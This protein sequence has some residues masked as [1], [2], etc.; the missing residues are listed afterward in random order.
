MSDHIILRNV[1]ALRSLRGVGPAFFK[2]HL[3]IIKEAIS[4][5]DAY[6]SLA[7]LIKAKPSRDD[8]NGA[9][10]DAARTVER[11]HQLGIRGLSIT[12]PDY[13][14]KALEIAKP[15]PVL[16]VRGDTSLLK[17][18]TVGIIGTRQPTRTGMII[19]SRIG[20]YFANNHISICNGLADGVDASSIM[21]GDTCHAGSVGVM[22]GGLDLLEQRLSSKT[23][24]ER[25]AR[26]LASG[27]LLVSEA[28]PGTKEDTYSIISSCRVQA[29]LSD[30]M[31]LV[32]SSMTGGSR[33]A[34]AAFCGLPRVLAFIDPPEQERKDEAFSANVAMSQDQ[35][36]GLIA[37][38]DVKHV[39][40]TELVSLKSR[41]DYSIVLDRLCSG[42]RE[43]QS[44]RERGL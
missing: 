33:F 18:K 25:A 9:L 26:L 44:T 32:Q 21:T 8:W 37:F 17:R 29:A 35:A 34:V 40:V 7:T 11:C 20:A 39:G 22:G 14:T 28:L 4:C 41:E 1:L 24:T 36:Q 27:G 19:A 12:D 23:V 3:P 31:V 43:A 42:V 10:E 5:A 6:E 30:A 2:K 38:A 16:F 13:P 15:S